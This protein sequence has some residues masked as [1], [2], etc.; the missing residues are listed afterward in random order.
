L[1]A[2]SPATGPAVSG[3]R[4]G[5]SRDRTQV[6][7]GDLRGLAEHRVEAAVRRGDEDREIAAEPAGVLARPP[8]G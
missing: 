5:S 6:L 3:A 4:S 2:S 7:P 1:A 8:G